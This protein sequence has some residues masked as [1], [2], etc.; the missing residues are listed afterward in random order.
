MGV[1]KQ[2]ILGGFTGKTGPVIG[3]TW[4]G[5]T[6]MRGIAVSYN[7]PNT[8]AQQVQR[9]KFKLMAQTIKPITPLIN[10][11]FKNY[12]VQMTCRNAAMKHNIR[13]AI[14]GNDPKNL[15]INWELLSFSFGCLV[16]K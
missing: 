10:I 6:Y 13:A 16:L 3:S 9:G 1:I 4:K 14:T 2:G 5:I 8:E 11:G 12:A 15:Q 7:N